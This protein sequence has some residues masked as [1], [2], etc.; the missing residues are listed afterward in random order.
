MYAT[1]QL[2]NQAADALGK[3]RTH[4]VHLQK[5]LEEKEEDFEEKAIQYVYEHTDKYDDWVK[6]STLYEKLEAENKKLKE[7]NENWANIMTIAGMKA[8]RKYQELEQDYGKLDDLYDKLQEENTGLKKDKLKLG[9]YSE[10][11][12][13]SESYG[14]YCD[15]VKE[16]HPDSLEEAGVEE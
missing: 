3:L 1:I 16:Y 13:V 15:W 9:W 4:V 10:Y 8:Q 6:G 11:M 7:D 2:S 12:C 5:K 14:Y